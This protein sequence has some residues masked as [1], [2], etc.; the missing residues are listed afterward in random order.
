MRTLVP[1]AP[2]L[3]L[4]A[5]GCTPACPAGDDR[6]YIDDMGYCGAPCDACA[7]CD[8]GF[9]CTFTVSGNGICVDD[10]FLRETGTSTTCSDPCGPGQI[11][12]SGVCVD[13]C[14]SDAD[15]STCCVR[16][17]G[18]TERNV[19]APSLSGCPGG[20]CGPGQ[21]A[22]NVDGVEMC[23]PICS[24][25]ADCST[26]CIST[27]GGARVCSPS[28]SRCGGGPTDPGCT[29]RT[30]CIS[31]EGTERGTHCGDPTSVEVTFRN[32]CSETIIIQYCFELN[33]GRW[34]CGLDSGFASGERKGGFRCDATGRYQYIGRATEDW[35][36]DCFLD[37]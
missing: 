26:C 6:I 9:T 4:L 5:S 18:G 20:G 11:R 16:T 28:A 34:D 31:V 19:C 30:S 23:L 13:L 32:N 17:V 27:T 21:H 25:D 33:D 2:M 22:T 3:A 10:A 1:F 29:D 35:G 12:A 8:P 24:S 7:E 14:S 36:E 15:C 37:L